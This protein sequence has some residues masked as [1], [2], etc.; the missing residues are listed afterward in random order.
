MTALSSANLVAFVATAVPA[1]A[2]EFY[3][4]VLGL[5]LVAD[6]PF[7][8]VFDANGTTLRIAKVQ[9]L[10]PVPRTVLGWAVRDIA[11]EVTGLARQGVT[12]ERFEGVTQDELGIW[13]APGGARV[14]WFK[15]PDGNLLSLTQSDDGQSHGG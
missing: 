1:R 3:E 9:E 13:S 7:A 4:H 10:T 2:R 5:R 8:L 14:A 15:D 6:D 12:F 11:G